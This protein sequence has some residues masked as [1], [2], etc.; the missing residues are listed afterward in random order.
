[1]IKYIFGCS[2][3]CFVIGLMYLAM[4]D[5]VRRNGTAYI[6]YE[7]VYP[8]ST[9]QYSDTVNFTYCNGDIRRCESFNFNPIRITSYEGSNYIEVYNYKAVQNTSPIRLKN[10]KII[11]YAK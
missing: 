2:F 8:D 7:I 3:I 5:V 6:E 4:V 11:N 10:S 9:I 1:M